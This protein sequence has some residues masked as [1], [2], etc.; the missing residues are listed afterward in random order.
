MGTANEDLLAAVVRHQVDIL[1]FGKGE[2]EAA[3]KI[4]DEAAEDI[5]SKIASR[6]AT[7]QSTARLEALKAEIARTRLKVFER[8]KKS[9]TASMSA[10][11]VAEGAFEN[12]L[13]KA[14]MP[15][16]LE[17]T[18]VDPAKLQILAGEPIRGIPLDGWLDQMAQADISRLQQAVTLG[19]VEGQTINQIIQAVAPGL[20]TTRRNAEALARTAVNSVS[21]RARQSVWDA[22]EDI[23]DGLRWTATLDGRTS[24]ICQARD[25][26]VAPVGG[27]PLPPGSDPLMP[28]DAR[29][30]AHFN[31][32]SV[33]V[34]II[35]GEAALGERPFVRDRRRPKERLKD[36]RA[37]A[38]AKVGDVEW[39]KLSVAQRNKL[40]AAEREAW[41]A[42]N[43]GRVPA[44]TTYE[45]WLRKQPKQ[46]Q[47]EVLGREKGALFR[48]GESLDKFVDASGKTLTVAE[49]QMAGQQQLLAVNQTG[50]GLKAQALIQQGL[51]NQK[52]LAKILE[53]F[54]DANTTLASISSY[55]SVLKKQGLLDIKKVAGVGDTV[56]SSPL[57]TAYIISHFTNKLPEGIRQAIGNG[58]YQIVDDLSGP[59]IAHYKAG[60]GVVI[61]AKKMAKLSPVQAQQVLA[62]EL[63]HMLHKQY[64]KLDIFPKVALNTMKDQLSAA[65]KKNYSYYTSHVDELT[66]ETYAQVLSPSPI[67]SQ[68]LVAKEFTEVLEDV[69]L[70]AKIALDEV[71]PITKKPVYSNGPVIPGSGLVAGNPQSLGVTG[72]IKELLKQNMNSDDVLKAVK[73]EFPS[74]KTTKASI[75]STK[76]VMKKAGEL[77]SPSSKVT[78]QATQTKAPPVP[79]I[80]KA[81]PTI[82]TAKD[83]AASSGYLDSLGG[84]KA[85]I[86]SSVTSQKAAAKKVLLKM[87]QAGKTGPNSE[88]AKQISTL[89]P[90]AGMK[91]TNVASFKSQWKKKGLWGETDIQELGL[92]TPNLKVSQ[93]GA[94]SKKGLIEAE[95]MFANGATHQQVDAFFAKHFGSWDAVKGQ[96]IMYLA[97]YNAKTKK[98]TGHAGAQAVNKANPHNIKS[99]HAPETIKPATDMTPIR[100]ATSPTDSWPPPPRFSEAQHVA[101]FR[102]V[103]GSHSLVGN[104]NMTSVNQALKAQGK[105]MLTGVEYSILRAYTG[106]AYRTLNNKL[107]AG[108]FGDDIYLQAVVDAGQSGL[109]K[110][111]GSNF[112][113]T[114]TVNRGTT[115]SAEHFETF[116]KMYVKGAII[117]EHGFLSTST[118]SGFGGRIRFKIKS[119][120][121]ISVRTLS[122]FPGENEVLFMPGVKFRIDKVTVDEAKRNTLVEMTEIYP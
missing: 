62:H 63:G 89:F 108:A 91:P 94:H 54:P 53:E 66:A 106:S 80:T 36:F 33:M 96:D 29:P 27:N 115:L 58:W 43:I 5:S 109:R 82:V 75:A 52:V 87:V 14:S 95:K 32:R 68:G 78:I 90:K 93:M 111:F 88:L 41:A 81:K 22:N 122:N 79:T 46:F 3:L 20:Q 51:S 92:P 84:V 17:T 71:F 44:K 16:V 49:L 76:S 103:L 114:G 28:P 4:L 15:F 9:M 31:C 56:A 11:S 101:G 107:R 24:P 61:S 21:N 120:T 7:G 1:R 86:L 8:L 38:R 85:T 110:M 117:E 2:A 69:L 105:E 55:R 25:G 45:E 26:E 72:Y 102:K 60:Q 73:A 98:F 113:F 65:G 67:T 118:S 59:T 100:V 35:D 104:V 39:K 6:L 30:P 97:E 13:L 48:Q 70:D 19:I 116:K 77:G 64:P 50:V 18:A 119:E 23:I 37:D 40:I 57:D 42:A 121:G 112:R 99:K 83:L 12:S 47:D 74:A 34:A 10:L